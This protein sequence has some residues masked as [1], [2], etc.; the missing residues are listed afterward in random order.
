MKFR[1]IIPARPAVARPARPAIA[2]LL[3]LSALAVAMPTAAATHFVQQVDMT[4]VP[5]VLTINVGDTVTWQWS[6]FSHTVTNGTG[7]ADPQAGRRFD[8]A[9]NSFS[10]TFSH[11][12]TAA[13]TVPYF[14]RPHELMGMNGTI[15]V[16]DTSSA[17]QVPAGRGLALAGAPNPFNPRTMVSFELPEPGRARL[18]VHDAA[19]RLVRVLLDGRDLAAGRGEVAWDGLDDGGR[20]APAGVYVAVLEAA[21]R[22]ESVKLTL[23]K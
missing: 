7:G 21:G 22:R 23:A 4:F 18:A 17:D 15:I 10:P 2:A 19:G 3:A 11:T 12:F 14:C 1:T 5:Q 8:G 20:A 6:S 16:Q 9:L 13:A